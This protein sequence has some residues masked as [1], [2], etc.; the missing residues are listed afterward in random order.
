MIPQPTRLLAFSPTIE[1]EQWSTHILWA[2]I[3]I[4]AVIGVFLAI[5]ALFRYRRSREIALFWI[6]NGLCFAVSFLIAVIWS[7]VMIDDSIVSG[8]ERLQFM[9]NF[10]LLSMILQILAFYLYS[11]FN[12][13]RRYFCRYHEYL[14]KRK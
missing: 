1:I 9:L 4:I 10:I 3:A 13:S 2:H 8:N 6:V 12:S 7:Y 5:Y 11:C 14:G